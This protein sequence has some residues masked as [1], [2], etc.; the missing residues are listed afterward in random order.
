MKKIKHDYP[1]VSVIIPMY[2]SE[3][4]IT[5]AVCSVLNQTYKN[6]EIII[7]DDISTDNSYNVALDLKNLSDKIFVYQNDKNSGSAISRNNG[8]SYSKGRLIAFLDADDF[9]MP[10]K[11]EKQ[12]NFMLENNY[13]FTFTSYS[14]ADTL[15][16]NISDRV[17][18]P[19]KISYVQALKNHTIWT[20]TVILDLEQLSKDDISMPDVRRGQDTA[21]WW[22]ILKKTGYAYSL[23]ESLSLY[24][25]SPNTLSSN[26]IQ[27][28]KRTWK[29]FREVEKFPL[30]KS[31]YYFAFYAY[32]AVKRRI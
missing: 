12:V 16:S 4:F 20:S 1:L 27:A 8:V 30:H 26:K 19:S 13:A 21:T 31:I 3:R 24:R 23:P 25:R 22:K 32:N 18:I 6:F 28:V 9:W 11:L 29:L 7:V 14:F 5:D 15:L 2:N 17:H 10:D